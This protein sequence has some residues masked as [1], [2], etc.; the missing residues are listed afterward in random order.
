MS[1]LALAGIDADHPQVELPRPLL[2]RDPDPIA[3][4]FRG[5]LGRRGVGRVLLVQGRVGPGVLP[6]DDLQ[7]GRRLELGPERLARPR[8]WSHGS[9]GPS[10][11]TAGRQRISH[12]SAARSAIFRSSRPARSSRCQR[13]CV[14][15]IQASAESRVYRSLAYQSQTRWRMTGLSASS[16]LP[17]GS[18]MIAPSAG[19][20]AIELPTPAERRLPRWPGISKRSMRAAGLA[21]AAGRSGPAGRPSLDLRERSARRP[22]L[23]MI[24]CTSRFML[25]ARS[26]VCEQAISRRSGLR[27]SMK[28]GKAAG[29]Q[30]AL[31]VL[32]RHED[33]QPPALARGHPVQLLGQFRVVPVRAVV[34]AWFVG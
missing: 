20:P 14:S 2:R 31:A 18:S 30:L 23:V 26:W 7:V 25:T 6:A 34:A 29:D 16:R 28:A 12:W 4:Q 9:P 19:C 13:V 33:H 3:E 21:S 5:P 32:R 24:R 27:P 15:T 1:L 22:S 10:S 11:R 17:K 8:A